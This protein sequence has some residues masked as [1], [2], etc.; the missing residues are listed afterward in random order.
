[1]WIQSNTYATHA[2][3]K[4]SKMGMSEWGLVTCIKVVCQAFKDWK[5]T[6]TRRKGMAV[7]VTCFAGRRIGGRRRWTGTF[8]RGDG[9]SAHWPPQLW[10]HGSQ[11][12]SRMDNS[13]QLLTNRVSIL[14][15][16]PHSPLAFAPAAMATFSTP[17]FRV[18]GVHVVYH[19]QAHLP[20][21]RTNTKLCTALKVKE[22]TH[23]LDWSLA[24]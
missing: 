13:E 1:M 17:I 24:A 11:N 19:S 3:E 5:Q 14:S 22:G 4:S 9:A 15:P 8:G 21:K 20:T 18:N 2:W 16:F 6:M 23:G 10:Q 7:L 12:L